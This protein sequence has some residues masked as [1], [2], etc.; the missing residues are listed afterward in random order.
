MLR[1]LIGG[2]IRSARHLLKNCVEILSGGDTCIDEKDLFWRQYFLQVTGL[3]PIRK[4]TC[5]GPISEGPGSQALMIMNANNF[6]RSCGLTYERQ[7]LILI[8]AK[9]LVHRRQRLDSD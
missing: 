3:R 6:A 4:I 7:L 2:A 5:T 9:A 8:G 1:L